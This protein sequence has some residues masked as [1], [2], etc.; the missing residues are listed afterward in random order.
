MELESS[1]IFVAIVKQR[2]SP[3]LVLELQ[4]SE[5]VME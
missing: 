5:N 3:A 4:A 2:S 1:D